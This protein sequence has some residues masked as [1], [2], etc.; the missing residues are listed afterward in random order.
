[1]FPPNLRAPPVPAVPRAPYNS[2][3]T[4]K[5]PILRSSSAAFYADEGR[6]FPE[7]VKLD[8]RSFMLRDKE[9]G[10]AYEGFGIGELDQGRVVEVRDPV[11]EAEA[12]VAA[13]D[14]RAVQADLQLGPED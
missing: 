3:L 12:E 14:A 4:L 7:S 10:V 13:M 6:D 1:M 9:Y 5:L 2:T 11:M 8:E